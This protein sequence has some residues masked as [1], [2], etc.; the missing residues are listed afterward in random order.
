MD[1]ET[2]YEKLTG[3]LERLARSE[4]GLD[5]SERRDIENSIDLLVTDGVDEH[6]ELAANLA[7]FLGVKL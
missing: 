1:T 6:P 5:R 2:L 3:A 7:A 4:Y